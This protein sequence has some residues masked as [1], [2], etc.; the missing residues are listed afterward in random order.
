MNDPDTVSTTKSVEIGL[1]FSLHMRIC[2]TRCQRAV[3]VSASDPVQRAVVAVA[4]GSTEMEIAVYFLADLLLTAVATLL[5]CFLTL[6]M[7]SSAAHPSRPWL[8]LSSDSIPS[9]CHRH[10]TV[11]KLY[12]PLGVQIG[13]L[14]A[15]P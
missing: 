5:T 14:Q 13:F 1:G 15:S 7:Y 11:Q 6:S 3:H 10:D 4:T 2:V 9:K 12:R 8:H